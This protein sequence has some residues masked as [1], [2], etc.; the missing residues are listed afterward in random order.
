MKIINL[1]LFSLVGLFVYLVYSLVNLQYAYS[2]DLKQDDICL[3]CDILDGYLSPELRF[4][5]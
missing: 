3:I 4:Y 5:R 1:V 2:L